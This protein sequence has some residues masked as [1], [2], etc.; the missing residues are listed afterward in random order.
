MKKEIPQGVEL[1][2]CEDISW[3]LIGWIILCLVAKKWLKEMYCLWVLTPFC[4]SSAKP[5]YDIL[6]PLSNWPYT[7]FTP[8]SRLG[9]TVDDIP[10]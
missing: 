3:K 5:M 7:V 4:T 10:R 2:F 6:I 9:W 8:D 1:Q